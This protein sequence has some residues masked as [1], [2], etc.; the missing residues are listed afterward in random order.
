M[1][2]LFVGVLDKEWSTN[3]SMERSLEGLG[4]EVTAFNYRTV[5]DKYRLAGGSSNG[6][7]DK[8]V[9]KCAS[10]LRSDWV[11]LE[12]TWYYK[13]RG[14]KQMNEELLR[15]V[16]QGEYDLVLLSKTDTVDCNILSEINKYCTTWYFFMDPMDQAY[17]INARG[18][19]TRATRASATFSDVTDYF[20]K[21]GAKAYWVTQGVDTDVFKPKK[22][23][24]VYDVVFAG[25]KTSKRSR[26]INFLKKAGISVVCFG[27]GW[28]NSSVYQDKL[29]DIYC[30]SRIILNFCRLGTGFSIR[31]FQAMGTGSFVLSEYCRDLETIFKREIHLDWFSDIDEAGEKI[32]YYLNR[33]EERENAAKDGY[34]FVYERYS[35]DK[36]MQNILTIADEKFAKG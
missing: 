12:V 9:E 32:H 8:W 7:F 23:S 18:Y 17:R 13:R 31:V 28:E 3:C 19:A 27:K 4:H 34:R 30:K 15:T 16:K 5:T 10:F 2:I 1:R 14:R 6:P 33:E 20:K 21:A 24:K 29:A 26:Y 36:I 35:W 22:V 25:T 11:P